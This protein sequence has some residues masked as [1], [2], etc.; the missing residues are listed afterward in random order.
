MCAQQI[1]RVGIIKNGKVTEELHFR[2]PSSLSIGADPTC[3]VV[4]HGSGVPER[5]E[6][7]DRNQDTWTLRKGLPPSL[8]STNMPAHIARLSSDSR[9]RLR[10]GEVT[11]LMRFVSAPPLK[12][13]PQLPSHMRNGA[14][15]LLSGDPQSRNW[16]RAALTFSLILQVAFVAWLERAVPPPERPSTSDIAVRD[17]PRI[18]SRTQTGTAEPRPRSPEDDVA[19]AQTED[20]HSTSADPDMASQREAVTT[21]RHTPPR[22]QD[23]STP[24]DLLTRV[25]SMSAIASLIDSNTGALLGIDTTTTA[26]A[27]RVAEAL[28]RQQARGTDN[29]GIISRNAL[30]SA[31]SDSRSARHAVATRGSVVAANANTTAAREDEQVRVPAGV[32]P[33]TTRH[34]GV[35]TIDEQALSNTLRRKQSDVTRCY[36]RALGSAPGLSGRIQLRFTVGTDGR[37]T[38]V[39]LPVNQVSSAV[40]SCLAGAA[41]RWRFDAPTGGSVTVSK[42]WILTPGS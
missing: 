29:G 5:V 9:V 26:S 41:R 17:L 14:L 20:A 28:T 38:R 6:V 3:D 7:F 16:R 13:A 36:E 30:A 23:S 12:P 32:R 39:S 31:D 25:H 34:R 10:L 19:A 21:R 4:V 2:S 42:S 1:L 22:A 37:V 11:A 33:G 18:E 40:G 27:D 8:A 24:E 35:G 15:G